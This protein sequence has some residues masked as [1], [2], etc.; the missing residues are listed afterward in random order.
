MRRRWAFPFH[1]S[2]SDNKSAR[3]YET[4]EINETNEKSYALRFCRFNWLKPTPGNK[5]NTPGIFRLFRLY[6][7]FRTLSPLQFTASSSKR[8]ILEGRNALSPRGS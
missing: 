4:N 3:E 6:R 7:L 1:H 2:G 5:L 8:R